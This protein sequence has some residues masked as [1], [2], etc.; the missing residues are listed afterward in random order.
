MNDF[1]TARHECIQILFKIKLN[2]SSK[3]AKMAADIILTS[4][5]G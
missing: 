5:E 3:L 4:D 2:N 1:E